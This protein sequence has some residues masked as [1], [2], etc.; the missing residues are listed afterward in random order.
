[1]R[2]PPY[3]LV[4][5]ARTVWNAGVCSFASQDGIFSSI[6][7][8]QLGVADLVL[9]AGNGVDVSAAIATVQPTIVGQD[10]PPPPEG[11]AILTLWQWQDGQT[12]RVQ[13]WRQNHTP[14]FEG[15]PILSEVPF[16]VL[17]WAFAPTL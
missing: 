7:T 2:S 10:A 1:M 17:V 4:A 13:C 16:A 11:D 12:L 14:G 3:L 5:R 9:Q 6:A 15:P 8:V